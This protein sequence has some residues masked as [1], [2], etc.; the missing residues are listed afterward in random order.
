MDNRPNTHQPYLCVECGAPVER[1]RKYCP[2]CRKIAMKNRAQYERTPEIR[3]K[4]SAS[5]KGKHNNTGWQHKPETRD[6]IA[7]AWTDEMR[8]AARERGLK[9]AADREWRLRIADAL[10][11]ENNPN[12]QGGL[13][14]QKYA[15]GFDKTLKRTI[16]ERDNFTCQLCTRTE[17]ELGYALSIHHADYDKS[18]HDESNLFATCKRCNSLV[19]T[20]RDYWPLYFALLAERRDLGQDISYFLRHKVITQHEGFIHTVYDDPG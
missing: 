20:N 11:G 2:A 12:W 14:G 1:R 6:K 4:T 16:R 15:P 17:D 10:S 9:Y 7:G 18:N 3:A 5:N 8:E 13:T 19:N